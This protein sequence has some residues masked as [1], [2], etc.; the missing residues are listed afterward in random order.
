MDN[1]FKKLMSLEDKDVEKIEKEESA[2]LEKLSAKKLH[3]FDN[4]AVD[5]N[6][7]IWS[8]EDMKSGADI[9]KNGYFYKKAERQVLKGE[10]I[11]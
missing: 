8:L 3:S 9:I 2:L 10:K 11:E 5:K 6:G 4:I 1:M 7:S